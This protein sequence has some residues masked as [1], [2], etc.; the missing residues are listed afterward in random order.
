[1]AA[2]NTPESAALRRRVFV[3]QT[4]QHWTTQV[5][6][7]EQALVEYRE[8]TPNPI[9]SRIEVLR[10]NIERAR[11]SLDTFVVEREQL[12]Q[13]R[14]V[15]RQRSPNRSL[16]RRSFG[17][18]RGRSLSSSPSRSRSRSRSRGRSRSRS[19]SRSRSRSSSRSSSRNRGLM[20]R[21]MYPPNRTRR[22]SR[23]PRGSNCA[24]S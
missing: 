10:R 23:C 2:L 15:P 6:E 17:R 8:N 1:M 20:P 13:E 16:R 7:A 3:D 21:V 19:S 11:N 4:I 9:A 12:M 22:R 24:I 14:Q 18:I 5:E